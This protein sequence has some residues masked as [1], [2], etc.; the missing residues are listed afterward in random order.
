M[1]PLGLSGSCQDRKTLFRDV[2]S[3]RIDVTGEGAGKE[4][5][6][7][8]RR[9]KFPLKGKFRRISISGGES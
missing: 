5:H 7:K 2:F 1:M 6:S 9:E 8:G 3:F 4:T